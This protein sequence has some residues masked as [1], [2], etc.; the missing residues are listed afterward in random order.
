MD[1]DTK[2]MQ[3]TRATA[4]QAAGQPVPTTPMP[5]MP[6]LPEFT[7]IQKL[8][9]VG[10]AIVVA[11]VCAFPLADWVS[12]PSSHTSEIESLDK[13][14]QTVTALVGVSAGASVVVSAFPGDMGTPVAE[15]LADISADLGIVLAAIYLEKYLLTIF[16]LAACR[17]VMPIVC[18]LVVASVLVRRNS[19]WRE[20]FNET[21]LKLV[22][23]AAALVLVIPASVG[24]AN[25]IE[26]TF[27]IDTTVAAASDSASASQSDS[28][29]SQD[30]SDSADSDSSDSNPVSDFLSWAGGLVSD[31]T[32]A[33]TTSVSDALTTAKEQVAHLVE[34]FAVMIVTCCLIPIVVFVFFIWLVNLIFGLTVQLP[35]RPGRELRHRMTANH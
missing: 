9:A 8:I 1:Q 13:K 31:A 6:D 21:A 12:S 32:S 18:L 7:G 4:P 14:A 20:K 17:F 24:V 5:P 19:P 10:V 23:F 22:L 2:I 15:K 30:Q 33:V 11:L 28:A 26:T 29:Q 27:N 3:S 16:G 34:A 35:A 25:M